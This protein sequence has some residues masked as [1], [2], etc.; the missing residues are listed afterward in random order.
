MILCSSQWSRHIFTHSYSGKCH[1]AVYSRLIHMAIILPVISS[2]SMSIWGWNRCYCLALQMIPSSEL[3]ACW[4][5]RANSDTILYNRF[6]L[7]KDVNIFSSEFLMKVWCCMI[8]GIAIYPGGADL[9]AC[10]HYFNNIVTSKGRYKPTWWWIEEVQLVVKEV[11]AVNGWCPGSE[12]WR[13]SELE[14]KIQARM[15]EV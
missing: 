7:C 5:L 3:A 6:K 12:W 15:E 13:S 10:G 1:S 14:K 8:S 9:L 11:Y 2:V 4:Y